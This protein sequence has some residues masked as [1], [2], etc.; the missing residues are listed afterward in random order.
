[1]LYYCYAR[2]TPSRNA[3]TV[4]IE[5]DVL[6][7]DSWFPLALEKLE[8]WEGIFQSGKS[9][10]ILLRLEKSGNFT[11]NTGKIRKNYTGKLKKILEKS[12]KFISNSENPAN[13]VPYFK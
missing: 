7:V 9:Q 6:I 11:Q 12:A 5:Q 4:N 2:I 13:M 3:L 8:K 1:M 10:G